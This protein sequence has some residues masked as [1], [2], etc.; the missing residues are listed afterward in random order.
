[1]ELGALV[2]KVKGRMR[3]LA[4][5]S[6]LKRSQGEVKDLSILV[7]VKEMA[8]ARGGKDV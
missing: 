7:E 8:E 5:S 2:K 6:I 3:R 1:M 4:L